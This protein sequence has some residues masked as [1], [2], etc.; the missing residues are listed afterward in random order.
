MR[1]RGLCAVAREAIENA[2]QDVGLGDAL[3]PPIS[4]T[5]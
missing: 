5:I 4:R 3:I 2:C 1:A